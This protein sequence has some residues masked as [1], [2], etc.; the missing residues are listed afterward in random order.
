VTAGATATLADTVLLTAN[1][2]VSTYFY[3]GTVWKKVAFGTP[4]ADDTDLAIGTSMQIVRKGSA[5]GY[6]TLTQPVPYSL[7]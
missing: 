7:Q 5:S 6:T 1:G 2:V 3:N 4:D